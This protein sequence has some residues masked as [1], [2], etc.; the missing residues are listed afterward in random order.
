MVFVA[1]LA[2]LLP[3]AL[4]Q[5]CADAIISILDG[6][7]IIEKGPGGKQ[8]RTALVPADKLR[9]EHCTAGEPIW[10]LHGRPESMNVGGVQIDSSE[11]FGCL[12]SVPTC[13]GRLKNDH[14]VSMLSDAALDVVRPWI[15]ICTPDGK[16]DVAVL[17]CRI[18]PSRPSRA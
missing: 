1:L 7:A 13:Q 5:T 4:A 3:A 11:S 12:P 9:C 18:R 6:V 16:G 17:S 8:Y 10:M 15:D 14:D 2:L